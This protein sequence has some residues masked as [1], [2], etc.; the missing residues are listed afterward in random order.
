MSANSNLAAI[1][2][3]QRE[4]GAMPLALAGDLQNVK[5]YFQDNLKNAY[6]RKPEMMWS[7]I[8]S[9]FVFL[10][11]GEYI[12]VGSD[13]YDPSDDEELILEMKESPT[14]EDHDDRSV[15]CDERRNLYGNL[16][17]YNGQWSLDNIVEA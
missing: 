12:E 9:S 10:F 13:F 11:D 1:Q 16:S 14:K 15:Q 17:F 5:V 8:Q 3:R 2:F 7:A 6:F 4:N